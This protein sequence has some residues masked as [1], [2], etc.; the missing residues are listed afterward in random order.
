MTEWA[1]PQVSTGKIGLLRR[2]HDVACRDKAGSCVIRKSPNVESFLRI[3]RSQLRWLG[4]VTGMFQ[5]RLAKQLL[6]KPTVKRPRGWTNDRKEL[7][8]FGQSVWKYRL[9]NTVMASFNTLSDKWPK[10]LS[11]KKTEWGDWIS[12]IAC[13]RLGVEPAEL[14]EIAENRRGISSP[15][16]LLPPRPSWKEK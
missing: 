2:I 15:P 6:A 12:D 10:C 8:Y 5:E 16:R 11:E 7:T 4:D 1:L 14:S 3:E 13:P 9:M